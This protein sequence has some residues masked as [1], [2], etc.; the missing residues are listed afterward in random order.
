VGTHACD[1]ISIVS[2]IQ[3]HKE[4]TSALLF[5]GKS[6][7]LPLEILFRPDARGVYDCR[8]AECLEDENEPSGPGENDLKGGAWA[9]RFVPGDGST[10]PVENPWLMRREILAEDDDPSSLLDDITLVYGRFGIGAD[11]LTVPAGT[12]ADD[13]HVARAGRALRN[14]YMEW[15]SLL[16][17]AMTMEM[18]KW[19][20]LKVRF[21][22]QKVDRLSRPMPLTI[23]WRK[24]RPAG[25]I[26]CSGVL[27][28]LIATLQMDALLGAEYRYCACD[29]CHKSFRV[30]RKDQRYCSDSCKHRQVVRDGRPGG[31]N[32]NK[33]ERS[34]GKRESK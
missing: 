6:A 7:P 4:V 2:P 22:P 9:F 23:E 10:E 18:S 32:V 31:R 30:K 17:E 16:R 3:E 29:G 25:V 12:I 11:D 15:R 24:G 13:C 20:K 33:G 26:A 34:T 14:E 28:A 5:G 21:S 19:A 27:D 1:T 8:Q